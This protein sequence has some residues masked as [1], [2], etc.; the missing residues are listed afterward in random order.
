MK[1]KEYKKPEMQVIEMRQQQLLQSSQ[2]E[3]YEWPFP[4][5]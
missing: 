5:A 2:T 1:R 4:G 3:P